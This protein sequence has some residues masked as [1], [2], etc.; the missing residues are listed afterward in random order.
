MK[1]I[2]IAYNQAYGTEIV[3]LLDEH[4]QRGFTQWIDLEGR[5]GVDGVPHFGNHA[6]PT[7]NYAILTIV[8]DDKADEIM[9]ALKEKDS[10]YPGLGLRAFL[11][12]VE[13]MA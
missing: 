12:T 9:D 13:K 11:W 2:F 5:G 7:Q 1:A 3:E 8:P 6:W 4:G 10:A